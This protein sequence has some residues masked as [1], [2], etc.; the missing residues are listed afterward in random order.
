MLENIMQF[1]LWIIQKFF[2][3]DI[4]L[5]GSITSIK[6]FVE[7]RIKYNKYNQSQ[8]CFSK[9]NCSLLQNRKVIEKI[10]RRNRSGYKI[11]R[12]KKN[13]NFFHGY[14]LT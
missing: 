11:G 2:L 14:L 12:L 8:S 6:L 9:M 7:I 5:T 10:T 1:N 4:E 3:V 13:K